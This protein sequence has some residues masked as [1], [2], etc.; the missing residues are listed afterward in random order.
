MWPAP[1]LPFH[2]H[3]IPFSAPVSLAF[4][5]LKHNKELLTLGSWL[6]VFPL[7][8]IHIP[9]EFWKAN[10]LILGPQL[11]ENLST[12]TQWEMA[13]QSLSFNR[14][15]VF[16]QSTDYHQ[17][18]HLKKK[19]CIFDCL[20]SLHVILKIPSALIRGISA[21]SQIA[22]ITMHL[23][24]WWRN[25]YKKRINGEPSWFPRLSALHAISVGCR[26]EKSNHRRAHLL[27]RKST[28]WKMKCSL[29]LAFSQAS[30]QETFASGAVIGPWG[31]MPVMQT[32]PSC[33]LKQMVPSYKSK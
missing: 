14:P 3:L 31:G 11:K 20:L 15:Y 26:E 29:S 5:H 7:L 18:V 24:Y 25:K 27:L 2:P 28:L 19:L 10:F 6:W 1:C 17:V 9:P 23:L 32:W 16:Y 30:H 13:T 4:S 12:T 21:A 8:G 33:E 22:G